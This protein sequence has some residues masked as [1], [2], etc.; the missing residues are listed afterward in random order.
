MTKTT[1]LQNR[2]INNQE[3]KEKQNLHFKMNYMKYSK[4]LKFSSGKLH[5]TDSAVC[6]E[7]ATSTKLY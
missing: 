3:Q 2:T 1:N 6:A 5:C 7:T 4:I